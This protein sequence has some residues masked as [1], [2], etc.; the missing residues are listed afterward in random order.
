MIKNS[1]KMKTQ[2]F[3]AV[4]M[5]FLL[6]ACG[7]TPPEEAIGENIDALQL[8]I[9]EK[10]NGA[11]R[12]HLS[13]QF[14]G[15][16]ERGTHLDAG[17]VRQYLAGLFLRYRNINVLVSNTRV[18]VEEYDPYRAT[19][20]SSVVVTGAEGLI[21]DTARIYQVK[22]IWA[23]EEGEWKLLEVSWD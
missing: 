16:G 22:G 1:E 9:Q 11:V 13:G 14:R 2:F 23:L 17:N 7:K 20:T 12:E 10:D 6:S 8:A 21:P 5:M 18:T 3:L 19:S 15:L 4:V